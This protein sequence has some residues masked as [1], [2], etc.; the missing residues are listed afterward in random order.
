ML[1]FVGL[2][3]RFLLFLIIFL[4]SYLISC[5]NTYVQLLPIPQYNTYV[6][7]LPIL[8]YFQALKKQCSTLIK[9]YTLGECLKRSYTKNVSAARLFNDDFSPILCVIFFY[10]DINLI[11]GA[12]QLPTFFS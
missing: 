11:V 10:F 2:S 8:Q 5:F 6:Q 4:F 12:A 3:V 1:I 9:L 7:L